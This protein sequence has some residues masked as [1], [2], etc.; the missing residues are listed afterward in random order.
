MRTE[1]DRQIT[2]ARTERD[3]QIAALRVEMREE[4]DPLRH[5]VLHQSSRASY[6]VV[7]YSV[8]VPIAQ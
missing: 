8:A 1:H 2:E 4:I 6:Y 7:M 5:E 3:H